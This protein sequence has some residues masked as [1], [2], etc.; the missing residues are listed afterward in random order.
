MWI[1]GEERSKK[2]GSTEAFDKLLHHCLGNWHSVA[3]KRKLRS[4]RELSGSR[5]FFLR[6]FPKIIFRGGV[7]CKDTPLRHRPCYKGYPLGRQNAPLWIGVF[8]RCELEVFFL[9]LFVEKT[10]TPIH[11]KKTPIHKILWI[12]VLVL[13]IGGFHFLWIGVFF[14][15]ELA[16][17]SFQQIRKEKKTPIHNAKKR[18]FTMCIF[19]LHLRQ[20]L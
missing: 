20:P 4:R 11:K 14:S 7:S 3:C 10:K 12:G 17:L 15:C 6:N 16:F 9:F 18:Q 5:V 13:W 1:M 2:C 19:C 8:G